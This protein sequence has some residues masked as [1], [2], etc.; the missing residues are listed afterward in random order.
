MVPVLRALRREGAEEVR[1]VSIVALP[2]GVALVERHHAEATIRTPLVDR[3][4]NGQK[5]IVPGLGDFGDR[6]YATI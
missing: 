4:L 6:L 1:V 3:T 2:E 5:F